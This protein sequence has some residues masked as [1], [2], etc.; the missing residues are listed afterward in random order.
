MLKIKR[1]G[2]VSNQSCHGAVGLDSA[3]LGTIM[4]G[5]VGCNV[6]AS[7]LRIVQVT[8]VACV[9][10]ERHADEESSEDEWSDE[11]DT[12]TP[13]DSIDPFVVFADTVRQLQAAGSPRFQV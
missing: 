7:S 11:E 5:F 4:L 2:C 13:I 3:L 8:I 9:Q 1:S 10:G 6:H 12:D